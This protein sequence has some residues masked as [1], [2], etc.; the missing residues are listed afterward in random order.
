MVTETAEISNVKA[1]KNFFEAEGGSKVSMKELKE[2]SET[3][4]EELGT[5]AKKLIKA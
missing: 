1:I 4:R 3:D 5:A 2:L